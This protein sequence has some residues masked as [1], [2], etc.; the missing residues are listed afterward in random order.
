MR[1]MRHKFLANEVKANP[2]DVS[3]VSHIPHM[4]PLSSFAWL[5]DMADVNRFDHYVVRGGGSPTPTPSPS[6]SPSPSPSNVKNVG[7]AVESP[8]ERAFPRLSASLCG[9]EVDA[10]V[11]EKP[12]PSAEH[13]LL[14][15]TSIGTSIAAKEFVVP[16]DQTTGFE[17]PSDVITELPR[18]TPRPFRL[19]DL[20]DP[21]VFPTATDEQP[22]A[23]RARTSSN[24]DPLTSH[25]SNTGLLGENAAK[26]LTKSVGEL[27]NSLISTERAYQNQSATLAKKEWEIERVCSEKAA[28]VAKVQSLEAK[29]SRLQ[30]EQDGERSAAKKEALKSFALSPAFNKLLTDHHD[31]GWEATAR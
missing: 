10:A 21:S 15:T 30:A 17:L 29:V 11:G 18:I 31:G 4:Q 8:S 13:V 12:T 26:E 22:T 19:L 14:S 16:P 20:E 23:K 3:L 6:H 2:P 25:S 9:V 7:K 28:I 27:A 24:L 5:D 1:A